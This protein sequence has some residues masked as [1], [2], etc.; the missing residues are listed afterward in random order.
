MPFFQGSVSK[1][2]VL[3]RISGA[4]LIGNTFYSPRMKRKANRY[5]YLHVRQD[6][7][8]HTHCNSKRWHKWGCI[9][10]HVILT[11]KGE[12]YKNPLQSKLLVG[13]LLGGK[14]SF[15]AEFSVFFELS[16]RQRQKQRKAWQMSIKTQTTPFC[17]C[18]KYS[19]P[20]PSV[21]QIS[22]KDAPGTV[23]PMKRMTRGIK[24]ILFDLK[25]KKTM[26]AASISVWPENT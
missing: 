7:L 13:W 17:T 1:T 5:R 14:W 25:K 20:L 21:G 9:M 26:H 23:S 12:S 24:M 22:K 15:E 18:C 16:S 2:G 3:F 6:S 8:N 19:W 4:T 11:R 10:R